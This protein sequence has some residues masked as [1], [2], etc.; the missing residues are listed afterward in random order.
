M[1]QL[2]FLDI[3]WKNIFLLIY[4]PYLKITALNTSKLSEKVYNFFWNIMEFFSVPLPIYN[5][6]L[7]SFTQL[8]LSSLYFIFLILNIL[9]HTY[10][11]NKYN[12]FQ[13]IGTTIFSFHLGM[14][15]TYFYQYDYCLTSQTVHLLFL[16]CLMVVHLLS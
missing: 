13:F 5:E 7:A 16:F 6:L 3:C 1:L 2:T 8:Y 11:R 9:N 10:C 4:G 14:I 12:I 15:S